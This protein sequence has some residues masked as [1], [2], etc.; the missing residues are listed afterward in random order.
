MTNFSVYHADA[1]RDLLDY[2]GCIVI[3][4][5]AMMQLTADGQRQ[6]L[7]NIL[8]IAPSKLFALMPGM[9]SVPDGFGVKVITAFQD[10]D[11]QGRSAHRGLVVLFER[12]TGAVVCV[13]DAG[14][15]TRVRTAA[16]T[17]V[18][19]DAL[20]RNDAKSL[21]IFGCGTQ[22]A[23]HIA[24]LVRIRQLTEV[25]IWGRSEDRAVRLV[26][27]MEPEIGIPVRY[28]ED[29]RVAADSDIVCTVTGATEPILFGKWLK[30]GTH[31]NLVGSSHAGPVEVDNGLVLLSRYI[32]DS[33]PSA[34]VA[35]SE[36]LVAKEAG[37]IGD[38]HI[39]AE[40]GEVLLNRTPGRVSDLD[41]TV[42]KSLGHIVQDLAAAAYIHRQASSM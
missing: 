28:V 42:Y 41:I 39:V 37:L 40:I 13:A 34:L 25:K 31:V 35:A 6:P 24:A 17:A 15:I 7:R 4:R 16:A 27:K 30:P 14:E 3:V 20:A 23:S 5:N 19:T 38:G 8:E 32:V 18:A 26:R 11:C 10:D 2:D 36:F 1:V 22:A 12:D 9:L 21:G 33:R 29:P